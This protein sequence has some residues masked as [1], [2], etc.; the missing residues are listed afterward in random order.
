MEQVPN[1]FPLQIS[2]PPEKQRRSEQAF[3]S[4]GS[5]P[6][7]HQRALQSTRWLQA[8]K[9][10]PLTPQAECFNGTDTSIFPSSSSFLLQNSLI[11]CW[12]RKQ[13][14]R[15]LGPSGPAGLQKQDGNPGRRALSGPSISSSMEDGAFSNCLQVAWQGTW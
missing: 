1:L 11:Y 2:F 8:L 7:Q 15:N 12:L 10:L 14:S 9:H 3:S 4:P 6:G 13:R 5:F